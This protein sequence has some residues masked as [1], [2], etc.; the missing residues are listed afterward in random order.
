M[1][2]NGKAADWRNPDLIESERY[3]RYLCSREWAVKRTA[4]RERCGG[5]CERCKHAPMSHVHHITYERK[6]DEDL[7]DLMGLCA[8][9]HEFTHDKRD[10][11]PML[12][13][14]V[15]VEG[16]LIQ[17]IYLAGRISGG[18]GDWRKEI[19]PGWKI[20]GHFSVGSEGSSIDVEIP[21]GRTIAYAGP[22][23]K[24]NGGGHGGGYG[25]HAMADDRQG[26]QHGMTSARI[27]DPHDVA[28]QIAEW[29]LS[30]DMI[31][32]WLDSREAYGTLVE[33]GMRVRGEN[34]C[35][36]V[37]AMPSLDRELWLPCTLADVTVI[38]PTAGAAWRWFWAN[39]GMTYRYKSHVV[40]DADVDD[41]LPDFN[42]TDEPTADDDPTTA[43]PDDESARRAR[44]NDLRDRLDK[45]DQQ[46]DP[47]AYRALELEYRR[48]LTS[49][50]PARTSTSP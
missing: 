49:T 37:V 8:P 26:D 33:I 28:N 43:P 36:V 20:G 40:Q 17:S 11:D 15:V 5:K 12:D 19:I 7:A 47:E 22:S 46:G 31:F 27:S 48:L 42:A 50:K 44:L 3:G 6:Y 38:A 10:R 45:V 18:H 41:D 13:V 21:D 30:A 25:P 9:C 23:W 34:P 29:V 24:D 2:T 1:A 32:A 4:V 39:P 14:P 35:V 16:V